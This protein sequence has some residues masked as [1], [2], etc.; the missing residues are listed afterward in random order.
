[1]SAVTSFL[2]QKTVI[3]RQGTFPRQTL[4]RAEQ[5]CGHLDALPM[6]KHTH[7]K[8]P[9]K[10]PRWHRSLFPSIYTDALSVSLP[11]EEV[12][13]QRLLF[14]EHTSLNGVL[15]SFRLKYQLSN[16]HVMHAFLFSNKQNNKNKQHKS[17]AQSKN[18]SR[19]HLIGSS[20]QM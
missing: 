1:M 10:N 2:E 12:I 20:K 18:K 16:N 14:S 15:S 7:L 8:H 11:E 9:I 17:D 3:P 19:K 6:D 5:L 13:V 4:Q